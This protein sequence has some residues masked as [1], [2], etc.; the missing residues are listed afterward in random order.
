M[1]IAFIDVFGFLLGNVVIGV[2]LPYLIP[3]FGE[4][5]HNN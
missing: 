1:R 2:S 4:V 3:T 5:A